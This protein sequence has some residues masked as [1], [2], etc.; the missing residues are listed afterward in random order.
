[1][2]FE[3][4]ILR[5]DNYKQTMIIL[6]KDT[7]DSKKEMALSYSALAACRAF[8]CF[9]IPDGIIYRYRMLYRL[10]LPNVI[11]PLAKINDNADIQSIL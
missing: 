3:N 7:N 8:A 6:L 11:Y 5:V 10:S 1:M 9:S 2:K 4:D